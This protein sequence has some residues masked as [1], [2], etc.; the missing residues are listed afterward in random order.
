MKKIK[1]IHQNK[2]SLLL[3]AGTIGL[4]LLAAGTIYAM[5]PRSQHPAT[6]SSPTQSASTSDQTRS[7]NS[8]DYSPP[9]SSDSQ[10]SD[11]AKS[12]AS[13]PTSTPSTLAVKIT[14]AANATA[15][16]GSQT[17]VV[18]SQVSGTSSGSCTLVASQAGQTN[19]SLT[20]TVTL[21]ATSYVCPN[22]VIPYSSFPS[23][24]D[25]HFTLTLT[26]GSQTASDNWPSP[27]T[28]NK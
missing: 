23:G 18:G 25:W 3:L 10:A 2:R 11:Q 7:P 12:S 27:V 13:N 28:V 21:Q 24:G 8:V 20:N 4:L 26:S 5:H 22:F 15:S 14:R 6:S 19:V 16:D 17:V 1:T 9:S